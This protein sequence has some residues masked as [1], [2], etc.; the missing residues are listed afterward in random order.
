MSDFIMAVP[1]LRYQLLT[2]QK[3]LFLISFVEHHL[4]FSRL[5]LIGYKFIL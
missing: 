3:D 1:L 5:L 4:D 2:I